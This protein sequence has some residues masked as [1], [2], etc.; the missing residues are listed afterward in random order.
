MNAPYLAQYQG[1]KRNLASLI[2]R[3]LPNKFHK[4]IEPFAG[5]AAISIYCALKGKAYEY[6]INDLNKPLIDLLRLVV[7]NP[8]SVSNQYEKIWRDQ[9]TD[10]I[11]HYYQ[12]R[13]KF[14]ITKDPILFLYLLARCVKGAVRYNSDGLFNQSPDKRRHGTN[15][16]KMQSNIY[17]ISSL[18][19]RKTQF[20]CLDY[21]SILELAIPGDIVYMDPPYQGVCGDRDSRY[22]SGID[23]KEF[24]E[25]LVKLHEKKISYIVS[26]DG[27]CGDKKY[28]NELPRLLNLEHIQLNAGRSTQATLLGKSLVTYESL[29]LT[30]DLL[31][32]KNMKLEAV[33]AELFT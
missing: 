1:S 10:S 27:K 20:F 7:E 33:N 22:F 29:Y 17:N 30:K 11:E 13:E 6:I 12:I 24:V 5:T 16:G 3:Y 8:E 32:N 15:P 25:E 26:Y 28:G 14:N 19:K 4:L 2:D 23:H 9:F 21:K 31:P 18:L